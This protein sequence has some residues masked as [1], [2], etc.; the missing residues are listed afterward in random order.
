MQRTSRSI[1]NK[2]MVACAF[3]VAC[4]LAA[5]TAFAH[6]GRSHHSNNGADVL[7]ALVVGAVIGGVL[8]SASQ[9]H[10]D[11]YN[12]GYNYPPPAYP[13]AGYY[14]GYPAYAYGSPGYAYPSYGY[15]SRVNVGVVYNSHGNRAPTR[16]YR[17]R[18]Y[19]GG[20]HGYN[21]SRGYYGNRGNHYVR[22]HQ[23]SQGRYYQRHGH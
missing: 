8:V 19:Y 16:Y 23:G 1:R 11:Y 10:H 4:V 15:G 12:S 2:L 13:S 3:V 21:G 7:G 14:S 9:N 5:P 22:G 20:S 18:S 17:G 6:D